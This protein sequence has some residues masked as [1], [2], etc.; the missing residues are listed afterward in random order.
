MKILNGKLYRGD[1]DD[2]FEDIETEAICSLCG[3]NNFKYRG[4][5]IECG[6]C[7]NVT[8]YSLFNKLK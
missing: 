3:E 6:T 8:C 5:R 2:I 4:D 1:R 7:K